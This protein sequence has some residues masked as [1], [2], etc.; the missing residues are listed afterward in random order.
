MLHE[1]QAT[2]TVA[3]IY[4]VV[5]TESKTANLTPNHRNSLNWEECEHKKCACM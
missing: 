5:E 2:K 3:E 1:E 4:L